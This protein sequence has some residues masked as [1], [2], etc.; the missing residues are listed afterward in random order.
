MP[1]HQPPGHRPSAQDAGDRFRGHDPY[2]PSG[3]RE[4]GGITIQELTP[5]GA[6]RLAAS[7]IWTERFNLAAGAQRTTRSDRRVRRPAVSLDWSGCDARR[8]PR[9]MPPGRAAR[10][11]FST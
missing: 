4:L 8:F 5:A 9:G 2:D 1:T 11:A 3:V 10:P 7:T 6:R